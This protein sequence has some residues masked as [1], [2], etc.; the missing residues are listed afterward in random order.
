MKTAKKQKWNDE[1]INFIFH[2]FE[3]WNREINTKKN[4]TVKDAT[5]ADEKR[6]P[7]KSL[8]GL[9]L[10][11]TLYQC[12]LLYLQPLLVSSRYAPPHTRLLRIKP[13]FFSQLANYNSAS[14]FWKG[15]EPLLWYGDS[16]N[17][18][19]AFICAPCMNDRTIKI[20]AWKQAI[21]YGSVLLW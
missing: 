15:F 3:L 8:A 6:N 19:C 4:S 1:H 5:D 20:S 17:H 14:I 2:T 7:V 9:P 16:S 10:I 13:Y 21:N 11:Q 18:S 12:S